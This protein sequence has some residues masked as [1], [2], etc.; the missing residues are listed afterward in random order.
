MSKKRCTKILREKSILRLHVRLFFANGCDFVVID[1]AL[2]TVICLF[3]N[4]SCGKKRKTGRDS[5][6]AKKGN[7]YKSV[8]FECSTMSGSRLNNTVEDDLASAGIDH[9]IV[10]TLSNECSGYMTTRE[11]YSAQHYEG[12]STHFVI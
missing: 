1:V 11:E 9:V 4:T 12:A 2:I 8:P 5:S 3:Q 6:Q 7:T 10:S